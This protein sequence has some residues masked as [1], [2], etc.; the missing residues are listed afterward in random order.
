M[1]WPLA[2]MLYGET[3]AWNPYFI[4]C[5]NASLLILGLALTIYAFLIMKAYK[6]AE[7]PKKNK[8]KHRRKR[9]ASEMV[10]EIEMI[11]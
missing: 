5:L 4:Y 8:K 3:K 2:T 6:I 7:W 9:Q 1:L 10:P 11:R